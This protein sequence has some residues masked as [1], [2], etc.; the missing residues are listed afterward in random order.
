MAACRAG[1][2]WTG[3][4]RIAWQCRGA[5]RESRS[6]AVWLSRPYSGACQSGDRQPARSRAP[7]AGSLAGGVRRPT[8]RPSAGAS[9]TSVRSGC[10]NGPSSR[11]RVEKV[12]PKLMQ[13][14]SVFATLCSTGMNTIIMSKRRNRSLH[15]TTIF[16]GQKEKLLFSGCLSSSISP[17]L[18]A[19][20]SYST[21]RVRYV[22]A[23]YHDSMRP[24]LETLWHLKIVSCVWAKKEHVIGEEL[25]PPCVV[26]RPGEA[27]TCEN[28]LAPAKS[29]IGN[30]QTSV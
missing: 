29:A 26:R 20:I 27:R 9:T 1:W 11:Q 24:E 7:R 17:D 10:A 25:V 19:L 21:S 2:C 13:S 28:A 22:I 4:D 15:S 14:R 8:P 5:A 23:F 12:I 16:F 30:P 18:F 3:P 6:M